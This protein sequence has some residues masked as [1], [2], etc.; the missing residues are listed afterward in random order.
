MNMKTILKFVMVAIFGMISLS[1]AAQ[2]RGCKKLE[3]KTQWM[4]DSLA[5]SAE[6]LLKINEIHAS[7]CKQMMALKTKS[8]ENKDSMKIQM[9]AIRKTMRSEYQQVL[10]SVQLE[11]MKQSFS[12][13]RD[14]AFKGKN[15]EKRAK[16][17]AENLKTQ[18]ML[19]DEQTAK[20]EKLNLEMM[21]KREDVRAKKDLGMDSSELRKLNMAIR[22][23]HK[24]GMKTILTD[25]Q[26]VK[27]LELR[28]NKA[29]KHH[30]KKEK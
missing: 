29:H 30:N 1:A 15:K 28:K 26:Y 12:N 6:Q 24:A 9:Q 20:V 19:T 13:K 2:E 14:T 11:K 10:T 25:D 23:E 17:N 21:A 16:M 5:L 27:W 7:A 8:R 22:D 18:L 3:Q 4:K